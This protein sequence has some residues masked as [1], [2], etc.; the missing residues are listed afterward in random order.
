MLTAE[1][2]D[3]GRQAR[4]QPIKLQRMHVRQQ[5]LNLLLAQF[6]AIPR[7]LIAAQANDVCDAFIVGRKS[8]EGKILPLENALQAG[9]SLSLG[10]IR[11]MASVA[12]G[13]IDSAS[14]S[15]LLVKAKLRV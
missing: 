9:A 11:L 12:L 13:I 5:V 14:R 4:S 8:A 7:H 2:S 1:G 15:L 6:L 10:G 3:A